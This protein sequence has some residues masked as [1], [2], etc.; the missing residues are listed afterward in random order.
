MTRL[1]LKSDWWKWCYS[2][3][4]RKTSSLSPCWLFCCAVKFCLRVHNAA[5]AYISYYWLDWPQMQFLSN[6]PF[7]SVSGV[8]PCGSSATVVDTSGV[9]LNFSVVWVHHR[10]QPC[11]RTSLQLSKLQD[12]TSCSASGYVIEV[13]VKSNYCSILRHTCQDYCTLATLL[14]AFIFLVLK[15]LNLKIPH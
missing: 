15:F 13:Q 10:Q 1:F 12:L 8:T 3:L 7:P 9:S 2:V 5:L 14:S 4:H 11:W 6:V